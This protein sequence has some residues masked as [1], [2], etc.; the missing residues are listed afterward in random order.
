MQQTFID[1]LIERAKVA[2]QIAQEYDQEQ[3]R[4]LARVIALTAVTN[5]EAWS[6]QTFEETELGDIESKIARNNDRPRGVMRDLLYA[7]TVGV[8]DEDKERD[9]IK[10]AKPVGV[11][12]AIV[13]MTVPETIP[14][15][16]A[17]NSIMGRN[18]IIFSPHPKAKRI[19]KTVVDAIG[20]TA[21]KYNAPE[22]LFICIE[23][24]TMAL[25][26]ELMQKCD[27]VIATGGQGLVR[28]A[29]SSGTPAYGVG[30]GNVVSVIDESADLADAAHKVFESKI[31]DLATGCSTENSLLK[32]GLPRVPLPKLL[33]LKEQLL[34]N[35]LGYPL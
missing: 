31:N 8:I 24:P 30:T 27:L 6:K 22:D 9:I 5:A 29:Y 13:P 20:K 17:M 21:K 4:R 19:T 15:I 35:Q 18:A 28:A 25:S 7:K 23:E 10:I 32:L 26:Q 1:G 12:G 33:L 16:K 2:Q 11:I 14:V 3:V 34:C